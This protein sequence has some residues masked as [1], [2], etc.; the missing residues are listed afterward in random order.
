MPDMQSEENVQLVIR[1]KKVI[2]L[3]F[4]TEMLNCSIRTVRRRLKQWDA[5]SSYNH[6]GRYYTLP[7]I[8]RFN[9]YGIW[10]YQGVFFSRYGNLSDTITHLVHHCTS[11]LSVVELCDILGLSPGSFRTF[12]DKLPSIQRNKIGNRFF[13]FSTDEAMSDVQIN[14][15][16]KNEIL[17]FSQLPND[18]DAVLILVDRIRYPDSTVE[19]C[20]RRLQK[21]RHGLTITLIRNLFAHHGLL[22]K[23]VDMR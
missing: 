7:G 20:V 18:A 21:I 10:R 4:L 13:Y 23:T 16:R 14:E 15:R 19:D 9:E 22:K 3:Q 12:F 17:S 11:G 2:T 5:Q 1:K 8:P 6:N